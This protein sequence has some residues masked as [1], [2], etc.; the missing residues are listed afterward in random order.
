MHRFVVVPEI[1]S[2]LRELLL[3]ERL[4]RARIHRCG[5]ASGRGA[6]RTAGHCGEEVKR[7]KL[8]MLFHLFGGKWAAFLRP[9][10]RNSEHHAGDARPTTSSNGDWRHRRA[11]SLSRGT[12]QGGVTA[13][14]VGSSAG[15]VVGGDR[16][17]E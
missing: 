4:S 13:R 1:Q 9:G 14:G 15:P 2:H 12:S 5:V 17:W 16:E 6:L 11:Q 3:D 7:W 10:A 8:V